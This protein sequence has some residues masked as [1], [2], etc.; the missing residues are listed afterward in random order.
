MCQIKLGEESC[1]RSKILL[2]AHFTF[3]WLTVFFGFFMVTVSSAVYFPFPGAVCTPD[4]RWRKMQEV[5]MPWHR[6]LAGNTWSY[7][8]LV[9]LN[10]TKTQASRYASGMNQSTERE[11]KFS[12]TKIHS[13]LP[14]PFVSRVLKCHEIKRCLLSFWRWWCQHCRVFFSFKAAFIH[15]DPFFLFAFST[16][17]I[18]SFALPWVCP[19]C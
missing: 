10:V 9:A 7:V 5:Q 16:I 18:L 15:V 13:E 17:L 2:N 8:E 3:V 12:G 14:W 4:C 19:L 6:C 11:L 1:T